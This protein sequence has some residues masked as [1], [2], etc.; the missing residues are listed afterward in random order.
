M[1]KFGIVIG[2]MLKKAIFK[3]GLLA[4]CLDI[5]AA[6]SSA[7][8]VNGVMPDRVLKY[9]ASGIF[10]NKAFSGSYGMMAW[11]LFFHFVI[12]FSCTA[13]FF[14]LYP[15]LKFVQHGILLNSV[16]IALIAWI[17]TTLIII[18]MSH[19]PP[20]SFT[21]AGVVRAIAILVLCIGLPIS[22]MARKY[23]A[24]K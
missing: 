11:G 4:G 17:V 15:K 12:A 20:P 24:D 1:R 5:L 22:W 19:V 3:T 18:P 14:F 8:I 6:C 23:Y 9:I 16:L 13:I 7:Y 10:G 21:V 2:F